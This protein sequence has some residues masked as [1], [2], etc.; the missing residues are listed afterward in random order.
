MQC[1]SRK[2]LGS[3][4]AGAP[5]R[6]EAMIPPPRRR[7][8]INA[9]A[10]RKSRLDIDPVFEPEGPH[11]RPPISRIS[12]QVKYTP[13]QPESLA[14]WYVRPRRSAGARRDFELDILCRCETP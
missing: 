5:N 9:C 2:A 8:K 1:V 14:P 6:A 7:A 13:G 3:A 10:A 4:V 12:I 11:F